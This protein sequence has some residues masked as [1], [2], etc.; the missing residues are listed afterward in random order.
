MK[1]LPLIII[2]EEISKFENVKQ[3]ILILLTLKIKET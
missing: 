1:T 3:V 2:L